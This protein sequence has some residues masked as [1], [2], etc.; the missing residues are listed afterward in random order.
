[1]KSIIELR[2]GEASLESK[3]FESESLHEVVQEVLRMGLTFHR[4]RIDKVTKDGP[5]RSTEESTIPAAVLYFRG[6][7]TNDYLITKRSEEEKY[8][9]FKYRWT[10]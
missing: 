7:D 8:A 2:D 3:I 9:L 10:P 6:N 5:W 4:L 1:M